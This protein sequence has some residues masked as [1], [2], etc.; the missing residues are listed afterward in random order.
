MISITY[1]IFGVTSNRLAIVGHGT[2]RDRHFKAS[3]RK[4]SYMTY[5]I[6]CYAKIMVKALERCASRVRLTSIK[7][8]MR[9]WAERS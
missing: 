5:T 8:V 3:S 2:I 1:L 6:A 9:K 7:M 4:V